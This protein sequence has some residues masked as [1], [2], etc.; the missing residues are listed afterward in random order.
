MEF[1]L[2]PYALTRLGR[3]SLRTAPPTPLVFHDGWQAL[4]ND[5]LDVHPTDDT[6]TR[7]L[8]HCAIRPTRM[9]TEQLIVPLLT[10]PKGTVPQAPQALPPR[11]LAR[12]F[13]HHFV[14][15]R[16]D[17]QLVAW[18]N[19]LH[20]NVCSS[21]AAVGVAALCAERNASLDD[22]RRLLQHIERCGDIRA[23]DAVRMRVRLQQFVTA[24]HARRFAQ[25]QLR[26]IDDDV[27]SGEQATSALENAASPDEIAAT[28][29]RVDTHYTSALRR[30]E[31]ACVRGDAHFDDM[32]KR[33]T[34]ARW[35]AHA[36]TEATE[37]WTANREAQ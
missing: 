8:Q 9:R 36:V 10:M 6:L 31:L 1:A 24:A 5:A 3:P 21:A 4:S 22:C 25:R 30:I 2:H 17:A 37:S 19:D 23:H 14:L 12:L 13:A 35:F 20:S 18:L 26:A 16:S 27:R 33:F 7:V 11:V 28:L 32:R 15:Q 34:N 29:A